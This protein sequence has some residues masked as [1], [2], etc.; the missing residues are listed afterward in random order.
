M[1]RKV[2]SV[3]HFFTSLR[4]KWGEFGSFVASDC[5]KC[6]NWKAAFLRKTRNSVATLKS[7]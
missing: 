3:F 1:R 4:L 7:H 2:D 6:K 5:L